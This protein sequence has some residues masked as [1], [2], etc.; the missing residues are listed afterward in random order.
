M[1]EFAGRF[2]RQPGRRRLMR[3]A[4]FGVSV[5]RFWQL[6]NQLVDTQ[7]ALARSVLVHRLQRI[8]AQRDTNH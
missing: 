2:Y 5:T 4:T 1:L 6:V 8:R 3:S 7:A